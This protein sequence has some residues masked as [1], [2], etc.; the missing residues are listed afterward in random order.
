MLFKNTLNRLFL[1]KINETFKCDVFFPDLQCFGVDL[2]S[3]NE[4]LKEVETNIK[5]VVDHDPDVDDSGEKEEK[6]VVWKY[7]VYKFSV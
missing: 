6:G 5:L 2:G 1:T 4:S 7:F 3:K